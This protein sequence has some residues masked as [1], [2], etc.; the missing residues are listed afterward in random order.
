MKKD[1]MNY[2]LNYLEIQKVNIRTQHLE[3]LLI[4]HS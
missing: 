3:A 2:V 1:I 4:P